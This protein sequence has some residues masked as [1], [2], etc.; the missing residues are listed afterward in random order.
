VK[1][2]KTYRFGVE[3]TGY[4]V[5]RDVLGGKGY[6]LCE[7]VAMGI[8]VPPGYIIP[9]SASVQYNDGNSQYQAGFIAGILERIK[10]DEC[11]LYDMFGYQPLVSVRSGSRES[12][13]GMMDTIL[14]V[15]INDSNLDE[16]IKRIGEKGALDSYRRFLQM[17]G[18]TAL[19]IEEHLFKA[20]LA[21][22]KAAAKA[23][24]DSELSVDHLARLV[25]RY[26]EIYA[27]N[28]KQ[29]PATREEALGGAIQ[30]VFRSWNNQRAKDYRSVN[31]I[32]EDWGTAVTVQAMVFGNMD[33][34]SGSGVAFTRDFGNGAP[35][36]KGNFLPM[37]QGE[38]VVA[39]IES[40][41][42]LGDMQNWDSKL[43]HELLAVMGKLEKHFRDMQDIEFTVQSGKLYLLQTR[44]GKR[45]A[46]AAFRV[47]HDLVQEGLIN[48]DE[49]AQR[50]RRDQLLMVMSPQ[51]DPAF[52]GKPIAVGLGVGG[53]VVS[54]K[55]VFS[56][57]KA[58]E[59][60]KKGEK[61]ILVRHETDVDDYLGMKASV[62]VLTATGDITSHAAVNANGLDKSC[63]VGCKAMSFSGDL[64]IFEKADKKALVLKEDDLISI[65]G[66]TGKIWLGEVPVI[67]P[68]ITAEVQ[69]VA[70]WIVQKP[71]AYRITCR[72]LDG[73]RSALYGVPAGTGVAYVDTCLLGDEEDLWL[74]GSAIE[75]CPAPT[76]VLD[77]SFVDGTW[78]EC[79]KGMNKM[80][81][82]DPLTGK[83]N[84][85]ALRVKGM[86]P[87]ARAKTVLKLPASCSMADELRKLGFR[88]IGPV[89]TVA[90]LLMADGP[91]II[92]DATIAQVFGSKD[93]LLWVQEAMA[94]AGKAPAKPLPEPAYW[95]EALM[96]KEAS[97]GADPH[98]A[99]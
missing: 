5:S 62:G 28:G 23:D 26:K 2:L 84:K 15:G 94:K 51:I 25:K 68:T 29:V 13:P 38:D 52:K 8:P 55:A 81:G 61:V 37:G 97:H 43:F 88:V 56:A 48:K 59:L 50:I 31:N 65:E 21:D 85:K 35:G 11:Y 45:S 83:G 32:P 54:G 67:E 76:V 46:L 60:G 90:D 16:W 53:P 86:D 1:E 10:A 24:K 74:L 82:A 6:G 39:A 49:A 72:D 89:K 79:D 41:Y 80:F 47:A 27:K 92:D 73:C 99:S 69:A 63:V 34:K 87:A 36:A 22:I 91:A 42:P 57:A 20:A 44:N 12:M 95:Y 3:N 9:C 66:A 75:K 14:N 19:G 77:L 71:C 18:A 33:E 98:A 93:A 78:C 96:R 17:Y 30:A 58:V 64:L 7:M 40:A 4:G 70:S